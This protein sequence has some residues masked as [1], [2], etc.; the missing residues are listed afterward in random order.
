MKQ[1]FLILL[2]LLGES[3]SKKG[4]KSQARKLYSRKPRNV[5]CNK[6]RGDR[7]RPG[8]PGLPGPPGQPGPAGVT[9]PIGPTGQQGPQGLRGPQGKAKISFKFILENKLCFLYTF[10][11]KQNIAQIKV[12]KEIEVLM[13]KRVK[14]VTRALLV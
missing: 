13:V 14:K 11:N 4:S 8:P 7:G 2:I 5:Q 12:L 3:E 1:L 6:S 10:L 9:G